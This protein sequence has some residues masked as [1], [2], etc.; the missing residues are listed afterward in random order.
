MGVWGFFQNDCHGPDGEMITCGVTGKPWYFLEE[1][2]PAFGNLVPR[3]IG[4][5]EVLRIC[6]MGMGVDGQNAG[7]SRCL[8]SS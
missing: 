7:V 8:T 2:Y 3:D 5:R 6:E 1:L 4:S